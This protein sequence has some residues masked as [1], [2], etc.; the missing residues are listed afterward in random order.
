MSARS[1]AAQKISEKL[2]EYDLN[3]VYGINVGFEGRCYHISFCKARI[4]DG[5]VRYFGDKFVQVTWQTAIRAMPQN[6]NAV[7]TSAENALEFIRLAF[8]EFDA[9][10]AFAIPQKEKKQ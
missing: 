1:E 10:A 4:L 3:E 5:S 7:F 2:F 8:V 9:D 6:G